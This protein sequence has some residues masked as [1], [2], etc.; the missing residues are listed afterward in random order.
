[1]SAAFAIQGQEPLYLDTR[2]LSVSA[3]PSLMV[4]SSQ[5][6]DCPHLPEQRDASHFPVEHRCILARNSSAIPANTGKGVSSSL[7]VHLLEQ[8]DVHLPAEHQP[9]SC[10]GPI[11][12]SHGA[13]GDGAAAPACVEIKGCRCRACWRAQRK[14]YTGVA[15]VPEVLRRGSTSAQQEGQQGC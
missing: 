7:D 14:T 9:H 2:L 3:S 10:Q 1:V 4:F 11:S 6:Q 8:S 13:V 12:Q 5:T 15:G